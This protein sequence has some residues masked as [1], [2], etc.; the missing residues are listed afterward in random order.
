MKNG[1]IP[2]HW[3]L[4]LWIG[5][6]ALIL[7]ALAR[8]SAIDT[9]GM[10]TFNANLVFGGIIALFG[11]LYLALH[12]FL[13]KKFGI[14]IVSGLESFFRWLGL[15]EKQ[16]LQEITEAEPISLPTEPIQ[17][18]VQHIEPIAPAEPIE[19]DIV[20]IETPTPRKIIIDYEERKAQHKQK[21]EDRAYQKEENVIKY[22]GY[23]LAPLV[24]LNV[25]NKIIDAVTAYIHTEGVPEFYDDEAIELPDILTTMDMMHFGWN[26]AKPFKKP[27]PHTAHFL[28]QVFA[29]KFK[30][31]EVCTIERKL[32]YQGSQGT[33][34]INE[35][36]AR[37]E[38][39]ADGEDLDTEK[40]TTTVKKTKTSKS[41]PKKETKSKKS[42][43][44]TNNLNPAMMAAYADMDIQPYNL[45]DNILEDDCYND[46]MW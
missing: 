12:E 42:S 38:I 22:I 20:K 33:I 34:K 45:G 46:P 43:S 25:L 11:L 1:Q 19:S 35:N 15:K 9:G 21:Q 2:D 44:R 31:V 32:K 7:A 23:T 40:E 37:F 29:Q 14:L 26:I 24:E 27:N 4:W 6:A 39:P 30:D 10:S 36:V 28:K 41:T 18:P 16:P 8:Q 17:Q 3:Q 13:T 5:I